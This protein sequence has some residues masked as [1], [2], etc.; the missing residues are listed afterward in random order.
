MKKALK[1][2]LIILLVLA[3]LLAA[4][5]VAIG[6]KPYMLKQRLSELQENEDI[7]FFDQ[8]HKKARTALRT[9]LED[10]LR[11][12]FEKDFLRVYKISLDRYSQ[13]EGQ[14]VCD[15]F[16]VECM[17]AADA[18]LLEQS[19]TAFEEDFE[20][21]AVACDGRIVFYGEKYLLQFF[22]Q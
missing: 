13:F 1:I 19:V 10:T 16:I 7:G 17:S 22:G 5:V 15:A 20:E 12:T 14:V 11:I 4:A 8:Y 3:I 18:E 21:F 9:N 2:I 6:Y